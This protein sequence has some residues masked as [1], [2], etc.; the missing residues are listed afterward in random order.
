MAVFPKARY[1]NKVRQAVIDRLLED[2]MNIESILRALE[3]DFLLNLSVGFVYDLC[4]RHG[5]TDGNGGAPTNGAGAVQ[6]HVVC[7]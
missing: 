1:D 4:V 2:G 5:A 7:G 3:R 6:R